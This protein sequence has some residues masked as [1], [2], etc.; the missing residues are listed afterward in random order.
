LYEICQRRHNFG[1]RWQNSQ[2]NTPYQPIKNIKLQTSKNQNIMKKLLYTS[3]IAATLGLTQNTKA[4][5]TLLHSFDKDARVNGNW[6]EPA[7]NY[8][9]VFDRDANEVKLYA[10]DFS[11]A[12]TITITPP[13][14]H[15]LNHVFYFCRNIFTTDGK[16]S[17]F[18]VLSD[19]QY[20][21]TRKIYDEDGK[22]LL[23]IDDVGDLDILIHMTSNN[24]Y[25]L[26]ITNWS[27]NRKTDI[28]SL[29]GVFSTSNAKLV[30]MSQ[31]LQPPYPNP[32]NTTITL[33]Y[34]LQSGETSVMRIL[35]INGQVMETKRIGSDFEQ[36]QLNVSNYRKGMYIY[37]VN[38]VSNRFVVN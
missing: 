8:Y 20:M 22:V 37:E 36:I 27:E 24:Q 4:Q 19:D 33:P 3:L 1:K 16:I 11:L 10:E 9:S 34:K 6:V 14:G 7:I 13:A 26:V 25:R 23:N 21:Y 29:P 17:F 32:S 12:K 28:Y 2:K 38:G 31:S 30:P 18:A 15:T 5:I 35:N